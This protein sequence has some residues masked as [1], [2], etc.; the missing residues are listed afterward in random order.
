M[1][2]KLSAVLGNTWRLLGFFSTHQSY[3]ANALSVNSPRH[4]LTVRRWPLAVG[5]W[6]LANTNDFGVLG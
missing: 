2:T 5:R 1:I 4:T 6:P 3:Q